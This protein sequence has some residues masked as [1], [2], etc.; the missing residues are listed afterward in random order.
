MTKPLIQHEK[1]ISRKMLAA[2]IV[3]LAVVFTIM[4][5]FFGLLERGLHR[6][7]QDTAETFQGQVENE[8]ETIARLVAFE[9]S[10]AQGLFSG[11]A[12]KVEGSLD[13]C[14]DDDWTGVGPED[15]AR[16]TGLL[17]T[18]WEKVTFNE[19]INGIELIRNQKKSGKYLTILYNKADPDIKCPRRVWKSIDDRTEFRRV[20]SLMMVNSGVAAPGPGPDEAMAPGGEDRILK[21]MPLYAPAPGKGAQFLGV[22]KVDVNARTLKS[23]LDKRLD[24]IDRVQ[25]TV[26]IWVLVGLVL[27]VAIGLGL[28]NY[29]T[30]R[31]TRPILELARLAE[32]FSSRETR[33]LNQLA[34]D[35][36][37]IKIDSKDEVWVL[38]EAFVDLAEE[39]NHHVVRLV[40][41]QRLMGLGT[42]A[43]GIA[44][45]IFSPLTYVQ[46]N[47]P[48]LR[49][50]VDAM[51]KILNQYD[52]T[53]TLSEDERKKI[54]AWKKKTKLAKRL[55]FLPTL[56]DDL[57]EGAD[58]M[59]HI[60]NSLRDFAG[61]QA[62]EEP[63]YDVHAGLDSTLNLLR[64]RF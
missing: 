58:R 34:V 52:K 4:M 22:V 10:S 57:E 53:A 56:M 29:V 55:K 32:D 51:Q 30:R 46:G 2:G 16:L 19:A 11:W 54:E 26:V 27:A 13:L 21:Y 28:F 41:G 62:E 31:V 14:A 23:F 9:M 1:S 7:T 35:L 45:E 36:R 33:N 5:S 49:G 8:A 43:Q 38:R 12:D 3:L 48:I 17:R 39:L 60:V 6:F 44:H 61:F 47:L 18:L 63:S 59:F 42:L 15:R 37:S 25:R 40:D 64:N 24:Y 50:H 20:E